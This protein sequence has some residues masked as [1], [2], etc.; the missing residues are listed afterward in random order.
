VSDQPNPTPKKGKRR[1]RGGGGGASKAK[2]ADLWRPVPVLADPEPIQPVEDPTALIRSLG[3]PPL[4]GQGT[5]GERNLALVVDK[6]AG[7]AMGLAQAFGFK[8]EEPAPADDEGE[9]PDPPGAT[10]GGI[11]R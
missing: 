3:P 8:A 9:R 4:Q 1:R 5:M 10:R 11:R 7:F 2:R 6:A